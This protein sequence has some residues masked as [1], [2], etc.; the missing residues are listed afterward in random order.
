M[1]ALVGVVAAAAVTLGDAAAGCGAAKGLAEAVGH[2]AEDL[3]VLARSKWVPELPAVVT[4]TSEQVRAQ[5]DSFLG[6]VADV[7]VEE[8]A[9]VVKAACDLWTLYDIEQ[10]PEK[11]LSTVRDQFENAWVYE[12]QVRDL[13]AELQAADSSRDQAVILGR[14][15]VCFAADQTAPD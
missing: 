3:T 7:P 9:E 13:G 14:A 4:V 12:Q 5:A 11:A 15:A 2:N 1:R 8:R 6:R 10:D